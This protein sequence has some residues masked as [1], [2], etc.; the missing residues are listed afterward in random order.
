[1][2]AKTFALTYD[3]KHSVVYSYSGAGYGNNTKPETKGMPV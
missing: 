2:R 3:N 1:M